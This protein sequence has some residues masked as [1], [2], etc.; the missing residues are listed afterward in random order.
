[1]ADVTEN[2]KGTFYTE[3]EINSKISTI[4]T[5]IDGKAASSHTHGNITN[6]GKLGTASR[7]VVTDSSKNITVSSSITTTELGYLDGV[8]SNI[9]TQLGGKAAKAT[10]LAG[11][12]IGDAYTKEE[13]DAE[14]AKKEGTHTH[15]YL[16][17]TTKY[18]GSATQGGAANSV[19]NKITVKLNS[20]CNNRGC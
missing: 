7:V 16:P 15:P 1:M 5:A 17:D 11:Y 13:V 14:L 12:G 18:A 19:A 20:G 4:N 3:S 9:Q 8:T 2:L 10:T 6:D